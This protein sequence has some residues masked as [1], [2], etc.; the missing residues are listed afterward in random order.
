MIV[1]EVLK[2]SMHLALG[3]NSVTGC[4]PWLSICEERFTARKA[5]RVV[6]T[7]PL[8]KPLE[9]GPIPIKK[10]RPF[11][12]FQFQTFISILKLLS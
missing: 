6:E 9:A 12:F 10:R 1:E 8:S 5:V 7:W 11:F 3:W 4:L 2:K